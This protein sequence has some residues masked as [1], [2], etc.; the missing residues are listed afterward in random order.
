MIYTKKAN[1]PYPILMNFTDDYLDPEFELDVS[2]RDNTD[3][4]TID[5]TWKVSSSFIKGLLNSGKA[6]LILIIKSKDNQFHKLGHARKPQIQIPKK[7]LCINTRT[8]MQLM[9][10]VNEDISFAQNQD[11]NSF[12]DDVKEEIF[13]VAG[14]ALGFSNTVIFDGS[15]NK[16]FE[17]FEKKIDKDIKSDVEIR[18]GT[19]TILI[20]YKKEDY[21]FVG[22]Q[23]S[24]EFN[25][26]YIYMGL[27]KALI[28]FLIHANPENPEEGI[29]VDE[30]EPPENPLES[31]LYSLMQAKNITELTMENLDEVVYQISDNL[32][33]RYH[34]AIRGL[35]SAN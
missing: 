4:Y 19:E 23:G 24:K 22:I 7:K 31:K 9:I 8:V 2:I 34:D 17:L 27:Q 25:Y 18:L 20:V 15:Q 14:N 5:I 11:L 6:D 12:Y 10:Q 30:M 29:Q 28:S 32:L 35:R 13:V 21:Q 16:P 1:F 3:Q 26:P 33:M